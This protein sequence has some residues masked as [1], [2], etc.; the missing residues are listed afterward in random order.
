MEDGW[1][2]NAQF[3]LYCLGALLSIRV[4]SVLYRG[5]VFAWALIYGVVGLALLW[6]AGEEISWGQRIF[7]LETPD[8]MQRHNLQH[9][10]NLHNLPGVMSTVHWLASC[11]LI[12]FVVLSTV[13]WTWGRSLLAK[14]HTYL[15]LPHPILVPAWLCFLS[16]GWLRTLYLQYSGATSVGRMVSRLQEPVELILAGGIVVFLSMVLSKARLLSD[17]RSSNLR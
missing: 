6:I 10:M 4:C 7:G 8:W 17:R 11:A 15:W 2:E 3:S 5:G 1:I 16:Y 9:E 12:V 13:G 14:R